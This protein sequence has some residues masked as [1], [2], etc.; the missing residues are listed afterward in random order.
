MEFNN[1]VKN[2]TDNIHNNK[3]NN[4][5]LPKSIDLILDGGAFNGYLQLGAL[6]YI[7]ELEASNKICIKRVSGTSV[8]SILGLLYLLNKLD[9]AILYS[10][11]LW[12]NYKNKFY[13]NNFKLL[14]YEII[15]KLDLFEY[16][17]FNN[18]LY[19]TYYNYKTKKKII[20][21]KYKN[22]K[23]IA[24]SIIKSAF[25]PY[26]MNGKFSYNKYVDGISPYIFK[27]KD[28]RKI[29]FI[30][31][32]SNNIIKLMY[33][34]KFEKTP[35]GRIVNGIFDANNFFTNGKS[36]LCSYIDNWDIFDYIS[37]KLRDFIWLLFLFLFD[38]V[39]VLRNIV[40]ECINKNIFILDIKKLIMR[41][42]RDKFIYCICI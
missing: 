22:N 16:K 42:I 23:D 28:K 1:I 13:L 24:E 31:L 15:N 11:K 29:L 4:I 38:I 39:S 18:K 34:I 41:I 30:N 21:C 3:N 9:Y 27:P 36:I 35:N 7:K 2:L 26:I 14:V 12:K 5:I 25:I 10:L 17:K 40:P 33:N 32:S 37:L 8:G 20:K 19:I 6:L